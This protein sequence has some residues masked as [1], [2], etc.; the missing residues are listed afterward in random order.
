MC[1]QP[2]FSME[3]SDTNICRRPATCS[4][5]PLSI[6][7]S[8][9]PQS[10]A[11]LPLPDHGHPRLFPPL[12]A[13]PWQEV[14]PFPKNGKTL[15]W[16]ISH[17]ALLGSLLQEV[18]GNRMPS[19]PHTGVSCQ[20]CGF[21]ETYWVTAFADTLRWESSQRGRESPFPPGTEVT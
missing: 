3:V 16:I 21:S 5:Q 15:K 13:G 10:S 14:F 6:R 12:L 17:S 19:H 20:E 18:A 9:C 4:F 11:Y 7:D 1:T 8:G 2:D